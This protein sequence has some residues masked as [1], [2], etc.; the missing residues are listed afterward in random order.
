MTVLSELKALRQNPTANASVAAHGH[1]LSSLV[2]HAELRVVELRELLRRIEA[3]H[4]G[5]D[6]DTRT[7][8]AFK[9]V[10]TELS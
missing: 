4:P 7:F 9:A 5:R 1:D 3:I 8:A 6:R 10:L 2:L